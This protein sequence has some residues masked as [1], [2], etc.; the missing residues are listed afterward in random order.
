MT[1]QYLRYVL[2]Y[3]RNI[4]KYGKVYSRKDDIRT[5]DACCVTED[6][7]FNWHDLQSLSDP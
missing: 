5:Q 7:T 4:T 6:V 2:K 1:P 3:I